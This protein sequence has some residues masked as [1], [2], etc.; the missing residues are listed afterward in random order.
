MEMERKIYI[1]NAFEA[2]NALERRHFSI[3]LSDSN[4]PSIVVEFLSLA[5]LIITGRE[6][7]DYLTCRKLIRDPHSFMLKA[8][9]V[10]EL[11]IP[12]E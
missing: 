11:T 9:E 1:Q 6:A 7:H 10:K 5:H 3:V 12:S 2:L 8:L 4:P